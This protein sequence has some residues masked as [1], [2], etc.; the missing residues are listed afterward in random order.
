MTAPDK[1]SEYN[2]TYYEK[3]K[4]KIRAARAERYQTDPDYRERVKAAALLRKQEL[5]R[6]R[7]KGPVKQRNRG[8]M[9]PVKF[10][11]DI[12][13]GELMATTM[14]TAGWLAKKFDRTPQT[15]RLWEKNG[16]LPAAMY[17]S[18]SGDRLYTH[19]QVSLLLKAYT[20]AIREYGSLVRTRI[21]KTSFPSMALK[22]WEDYPLGIE[23]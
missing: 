16:I 10:N 4:A 12:G 14:F 13:N 5:K 23:L 6:N 9:R 17:R 8:P 3:N 21:S 18:D 22:I 2:K 1:Q 15:I 20:E 19:L 7:K 11:V